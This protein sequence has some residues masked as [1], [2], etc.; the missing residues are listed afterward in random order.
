MAPS[1]Y[2]KYLGIYIY[3]N[4]SWDIH[5]Q[6]KSKKI[7]RANGLLSKLRHYIPK[8]TLV[9]V[10]YALLYS[11]LIYGCS[12]WSIPSQKNINII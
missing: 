6:V 1:K 4:L 5:I 7:S 8:D 10:Y 11:H 9:S 3:E 12:V 2:V